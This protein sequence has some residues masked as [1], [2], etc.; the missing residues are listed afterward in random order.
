MKKLDMSVV[1]NYKMGVVYVQRACAAIATKQRYK[2]KQD[3][4]LSFSCFVSL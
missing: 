3:G 1:K 4:R 2:K